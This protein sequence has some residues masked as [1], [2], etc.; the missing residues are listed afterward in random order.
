M[1]G[2]HA[3]VASL[4]GT[5]LDVIMDHCLV[6]PAWADELTAAFAGLDVLRV[7]VT[8][9]L[10]VVEE[11]ERSRGDRT[12]GWASARFDVIHRYLPYDLT[13][14]TSRD[15]PSG[16]AEAVAAEL[17]RRFRSSN[18]PTVE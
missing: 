13:V 16:C 1:R 3:S 15:D 5:G 6:E 11:R 17:A 8:C 18:G 4:A 2:L 9:P 12:L 10:A 14:D 7:G